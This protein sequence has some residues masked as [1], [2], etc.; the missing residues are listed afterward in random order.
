MQPEDFKE[1]GPGADDGQEADPEDPSDFGRIK[2]ILRTQVGERC[3]LE[4]IY[5]DDSIQDLIRPL[6]EFGAVCKFGGLKLIYY[7][8]GSKSDAIVL[9]GEGNT[10]IAVNPKCPRDK[11]IQ[12]LSDAF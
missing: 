6:E 10:V 7:D 9:A 11:I 12:V 5:Q 4:D 1:T 2:K 8:S 3:G